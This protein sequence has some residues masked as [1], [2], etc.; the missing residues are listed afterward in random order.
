M[1]IPS[2]GNDTANKKLVLFT[3]GYS[4]VTEAE[5][6]QKNKDSQPQL[7]NFNGSYIKKAY[8]ISR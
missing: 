4:F 5:K 3:Y 7:K 6:S 2:Q 8:I 1:S